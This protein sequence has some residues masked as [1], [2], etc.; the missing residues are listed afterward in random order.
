VKDLQH[1]T[2]DAPRAGLRQVLLADG[3]LELR[4][5]SGAANLVERWL[6]H[7]PPTEPNPINAVSVLAVDVDPEHRAETAPPGT[8][9]LTLG[10]IGLWLDSESNT[11]Q[12]S[13]APDGARGKIYLAVPGATITAPAN[14]EP[15]V[16]ADVFG[17]LTITAAL[18]LGRLGRALVHAAAVVSPESGEAWLLVGDAHSGK[19][20]TTAN[21]IRAGWRYLSD[22]HVV[23]S[24]DS[25]GRILAEGWPRDFH[26]DEGWE[27][28]GPTGRRGVIAFSEV[29]P[30]RWT[31]V[32]ALGG[33]IFPRVDAAR[34]TRWAPCPGADA[35]GRLVRQSPWLLADREA[36][37]GGLE[38]L[39]RCVMLGAAELRLGLD[40]FG[41]PALLDSCVAS[42]TGQARE[43]LRARL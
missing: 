42:L 18:L 23:L 14:N 19:S 2:D 38:L 22:D 29:A 33:V 35:L 15:D 9:T 41:D 13:G 12:L 43:A 8:P 5:A 11:A 3:S 20:T 6:P 27:R 17:M 34:P 1:L 7:L 37:R 16:I 39:R 31:R 24:R 30:D 28:G 25:D 21:L 26:L 40:T 36:G 32:A 4:A 10:R